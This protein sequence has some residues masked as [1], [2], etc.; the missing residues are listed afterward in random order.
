MKS[1]WKPVVLASLILMVTM[2]IRQ[3]VGLFVHPIVA[4]GGVS[5]VEISMAFAIGQLV[6]GL[7][8]PLFGAWADKGNAFKPLL[9]G[10]I[11][12]TLGQIATLWA[13]TPIELILAQGIFSPTGAA[14]GS[15]SVII[16]VV[17]ARI[18]AEKRTV[19]SGFVNAGGSI[20]Q[21]VFAPMVQ[22]VMHLRD[23]RTS[24]LLLGSFA[25]M[26]IIPAKLLCR[27]KLYSAA[28]PKISPKISPTIS[29][30]N[31][32]ARS[33]L[34]EQL[35][36][37]LRNKSYILLNA[38]FF[39]CGFHVA[40]LTTHLPSESLLRGHAPAVA[41]AGLSIIGLNNIVGSIAVGF[42]GK[43]VRQKFILASVYALRAL[44]ILAY[45][46][47]A[48]TEPAMYV[49]SC[50]IGLTW[51]ASVSPT[52]IL[53]SK[54][55]GTRY[56]ATLFG[57]TFLSHQVGAFFGA[58]LGGVAMQHAGNLEIMWIA[59][60]ALALLAALVNLPIKEQA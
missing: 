15:F 5:I 58:W 19:A 7:C 50:A 14:A 21:F 13:T 2:G 52:A 4:Q 6:W 49:F 39:T 31:P 29:P 57:L 46:F 59:D 11:C 23:Y 3:T 25:L 38:G 56:L 60:A 43:H 35:G 51:L 47:S 10:A 28:Q 54:L 27:I 45:M 36:V 42:I 24:L 1:M 32:L 44:I 55:F 30:D 16:G 34:R 9:A 33:G 12:L 8:Q 22:L 40:F 37:A 53:V 26:T 48:R 18:A 41:A 20:G 17:V